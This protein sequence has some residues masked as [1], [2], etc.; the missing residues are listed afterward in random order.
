MFQR[1][2]LHLWLHLYRSPIGFAAEKAAA[3][4]AE[5]CQVSTSLG[6]AMNLMDFA[7][8]FAIC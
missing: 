7:A 4:E 6:L 3:N 2:A 8:C 1:S 5:G